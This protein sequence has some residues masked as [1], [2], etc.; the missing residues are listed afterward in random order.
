MTT[1]EH[2]SIPT[3][4]WSTSTSVL[5]SGA[6]AAL[7]ATVVNLALF[8]VGRAGGVEF[9]VGARGNAGESQV[10]WS[11]VIAASLVTIAIGTAVAAAAVRRSARV[12]RAVLVAGLVV[13]VVSTGAPLT[14]GSNAPTRLL[15]ASMHVVAGGCLTVALWRHG[16]RTPSAG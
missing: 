16:R 14:M 15:L 9:L 11:H 10:V 1:N 3:V 5:R 2:V 6:R 8:A 13:T 7:V 12:L 4:A